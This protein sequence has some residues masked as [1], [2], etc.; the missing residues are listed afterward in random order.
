[1][2]HVFG[3]IRYRDRCSDLRKNKVR[4]SSLALITAAKEKHYVVV[5]MYV[6]PWRRGLV[7]SSPLAIEETGAMCRREIES[8]QG[9][10]VIVFN[11][12]ERF[13]LL[14]QFEL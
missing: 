4:G 10:R 7:V 9:I 12:T 1:V 2:C 8:R 5:Y 13:F 14:F 11:N 6:L 3:K